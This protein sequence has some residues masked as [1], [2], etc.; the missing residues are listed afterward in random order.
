M[1]IANR[2]RRRWNEV[3][4]G[5][6]SVLIGAH[7]FFIHPWFVALAWWKLHGFPWDP[8]LWAAFFLHDIG[9]L[10]KPNLDGP[11]GEKHVELGALIMGSLFDWE[12]VIEEDLAFGSS[13]VRYAEIMKRLVEWQKAGKLI[14]VV[15]V[16]GWA[17]VI[18]QENKHKWETFTRY[19]SRFYS[20]NDEVTPSPLCAADKLALALTP[21]W[22][23]L[24]LVR[25]TGEIKEYMELSKARTDAGEPKYSSQKLSTSSEKSWYFDV[26]EYARRWA[27][28]HYDGR[29]DTWTPQMKTPQE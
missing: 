5:T 24:P 1:Q 6:R 7:C 10:G 28:E 11:E 13:E 26:Q 19:H 2:I 14:A 25:L 20:K 9:Y 18:R 15:M 29:P 16:D 23:Y 8:R 12:Q 4:L 27:M 3:S 17:R 22:L 21:W